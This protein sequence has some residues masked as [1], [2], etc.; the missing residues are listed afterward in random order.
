MSIRCK[1]GDIKT[2]EDIW[3]LTGVKPEDT[4][5]IVLEPDEFKSIFKDEEYYNLPPCPEEELDIMRHELH[6]LYTAGRIFEYDF[7]I[8]IPALKGYFRIGRERKDIRE[9]QLFPDNLIH[10][11]SDGTD[12]PDFLSRG[13]IYDIAKRLSKNDDFETNDDNLECIIENPN[14]NFPEYR[15]TIREL[16]EKIMQVAGSLHDNYE[17]YRTPPMFKWGYDT[18]AFDYEI[19]IPELELTLQKGKEFDIDEEMDKEAIEEDD[20][21][22]YIFFEPDDIL[23]IRHANGEYGGTYSC[24][25]SYL[26]NDPDISELECIIKVPYRSER[27]TDHAEKFTLNILNLHDF[28]EEPENAAYKALLDLGNIESGYK[29]ISPDLDLGSHYRADCYIT[30][31]Y[32]EENDIDIVIG[33]GLGGFYAAYISAKH[34]I[35]AILVNPMLMPFRT[36][37]QLG[38]HSWFCMEMRRFGDMTDFVFSH[39]RIN[40][41]CI[42]GSDDEVIDTHDFTQYLTSNDRFRIVPGGKHSGDTLPLKEYFREIMH[43][44]EITLPIQDE[45]YQERMDLYERTFFSSDEV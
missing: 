21:Y 13:N 41:S 5:C 8:I 24:L 19:H 20:D 30:K 15:C 4:V 9:V 23:I 10:F 35:P 11:Y 29:I 33:T 38:Y 14:T 6:T 40:I 16:E 31:K 2:N 39:K 32:L 18:Y 7:R 12:T 26:I 28:K 43:F 34:H 1:L 45:A 3:K 42:I 44:Y 17:L 25:Y 22:K 37:P 27:K 36:L